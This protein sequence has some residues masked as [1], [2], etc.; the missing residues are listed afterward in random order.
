MTEN[1]LKQPFGDRLS[2]ALKARKTPLCVGIDPH[3]SLM[4]SLFRATGQA[5]QIEK[6]YDFS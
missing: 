6:L 2:N 3:I 4:P 5:E 1:S